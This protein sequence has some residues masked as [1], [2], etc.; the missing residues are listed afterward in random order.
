MFFF[1]FFDLGVVFPFY[2]LWFKSVAIRL[3][4]FFFVF[5]IWGLFFH[6]IAFGLSP[7]G[8][9]YDGFFL[10][11]DLGL[12]LPFYCLWFKSVGFRLWWIF[13]C[14]LIWGFL[15]HFIAFGWSP[16]CLRYD[17]FFLFFYLGL[18]FSFYC[19]WFKSVGFR[20]WS[21]F[22]CFLIFGFYFH[23][24]A[25]GLSRSGL[26]YDG[27]FLFFDL[28]LLFPLY[29]LWLKA[30]GFRLWWIFFVFLI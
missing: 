9:G 15:F 18:L 8:L 4:W 2:Y 16:S 26:D 1:F 24:I 29:C 27:F 5:L 25:F 21:I 13:F 3:W 30:V 20:P 17:G 14:F 6:F 11:F 7:S 10:F 22:F 12:L 28:G 23:F 19:L